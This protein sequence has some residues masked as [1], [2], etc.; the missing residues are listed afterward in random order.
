MARHSLA[1]GGNPKNGYSF[2]QNILPSVPYDPDQE[3]VPDARR[4]TF[5]GTRGESVDDSHRDQRADG[6]GRHVQDLRIT[7]RPQALGDLEQPA[8]DRSRRD[9][10]ET[11]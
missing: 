4:L 3:I 1:L 2:G 9:R 5:D 7:Q 8:I 10:G 6:A 11:G